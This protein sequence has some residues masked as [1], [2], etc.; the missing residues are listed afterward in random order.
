MKFCESIRR[1]RQKRSRTTLPEEK[2]L[3]LWA[4]KPGS[5]LLA[6]QSYHPATQKDFMI[7]LIRVLQ[8][9]KCLVIWALRYPECWEIEIT[10]TDLLRMLVL[11]ALQINASRLISTHFP[12]TT[13][14]IQEASTQRDWL[15]LLQQAT[16]GLDRI[17]IALDMELLSR[18]GSDRLEQVR[19]L[20]ESLRISLP[21]SVKIIASASSF[22]QDFLTELQDTGGCV[23]F[24]MDDR[25]RAQRPSV[26]ERKRR[27]RGRMFG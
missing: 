3:K 16:Q 20:V 13:L 24:R 23:R 21:A 14:H 26:L 8:D 4:E 2:S 17:F 12:I 11:Q 25:R 19:G 9:S 18:I 22:D 27:P 1:R 7:E 15:S 6:T 10:I 5:S